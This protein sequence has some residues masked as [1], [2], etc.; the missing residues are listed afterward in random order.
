M[1][2]LVRQ[3]IKVEGLGVISE[4]APPE[5]DG[6]GQLLRPT[7]VVTFFS[8]FWQM[9]GVVTQIVV[10]AT[11]GA[12]A[13]MDAFLAAS[14]L[15]Q[16]VVSVLVST[17]SSVFIPVFVSHAATKQEDEAWL[18]ASGVINLCLLVLGGLVIGG[19]VFAGPL[20]Q[21]TTPGL[22][23]E[24][25]RLASR[26][27]MITWPAIL[28]TG[29]I[30]LLTGIYQAQ[31]CFGWPAAVLVIGALVNLGLVSVLAR[32]LG[33]IGLAIASTTGVVLQVA[34]LLRVA[35][36]PG[37]YRLVLP[38]WHPG[39]QQVLRL[40]APMLITNALIWWTPV[41]DRYLASG[42]PE[43]SISHLN[44]ALRLTTLLSLLIGTGIA[45]V[46][47]PRMASSV[48]VGTTADLK[49]TASL[50]LRVMWLAIAPAIVLGEVLALPL[51]SVAFQRGQFGAVDTEAVA[52]LL[53]VYLLALAGM[54]LGSI[55]SRI[56]YA[57]KDTRPLAVFG[58]IEALAYIVYT[59]LLVQ[60][61]GVTG[62]A[63]G[64][65]LFFYISLLWQLLVVRHKTGRT[66]GRTILGSFARI[67]F[68]ALL[69]GA[70]AW[71]VTLMMPNLWLQLLLGG[72][73]GLVIYAI[74]LLG[75]GSGEARV[76]WTQWLDRANRSGWSRMVK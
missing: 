46:I 16:Y 73:L 12:K 47:F 21:L 38:W 70:A 36:G 61:F 37:R 22:K 25:L 6:M 60:R 41:I 53:Q 56:F 69:G 33:V 71:V 51:V 3:N 68:A 42:L 55:T 67:G 24:T 62:I 52:D 17:L 20:L 48:A 76:I 1:S 2:S 15:P 44:Y 27:A 39:L 13:D 50:S 4:P 63:W 34:L 10:A 54:C 23:P 49:R 11:F 7:L 8:L 19:L 29:M 45:T 18:L 43:G 58:V 75:L 26:V 9:I 40:L 28:A 35:W 59:P 30:S 66:G 31:D 64:Y 74:A 32:P 65:V 5:L 57:L 72:A 14:T